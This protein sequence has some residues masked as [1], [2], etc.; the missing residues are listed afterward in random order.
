MSCLDSR[1]GSGTAAGRRL[2]RH[3]GPPQQPEETEPAAAGDD[4]VVVDDPEPEEEPDDDVQPV[5]D[6]GRTVENW[7]IVDALDLAAGS[8]PG[9]MT[10]LQDG[11]LLM[12]AG[13]SA[14]NVVDLDAGQAHLVGAMTADGAPLQGYY[15]PVA[16]FDD[17]LLYRYFDAAEMSRLRIA[18]LDGSGEPTEVE[19]PQGAAYLSEDGTILSQDGASGVVVYAVDDSD[20]FSLHEFGAEGPAGEL[21]AVDQL[22]AHEV[23]SVTYHLGAVGGSYWF[24]LVEEQDV[25]SIYSDSVYTYARP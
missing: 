8:N 15:A 6:A 10:F 16:V 21:M 23:P 14:V 1:D 17:Q 11:S 3:T 20:G 22:V 2:Q 7:R 9:S 12:P 13:S 18:P 24:A 25:T 4:A 5:A 19:F